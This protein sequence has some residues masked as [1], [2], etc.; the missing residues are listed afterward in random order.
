LVN[1]FLQIGRAD[2]AEKSL[3][4]TGE[5]IAMGHRHYFFGNRHDKL[6]RFKNGV[7]KIL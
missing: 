3:P 7:N 1:G 4:M 2:G 5:G 6:L